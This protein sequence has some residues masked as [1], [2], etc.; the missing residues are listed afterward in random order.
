LHLACRSKGDEEL[1]LR[2][3][4]KNGTATAA[5]LGDRNPTA[6]PRPSLKERGKGEIYLLT[7]HSFTIY[8]LQF[9]ISM[10][11]SCL[12]Q[13]RKGIYDLRF[14]IYNLPF[15]LPFTIYH[16][17]VLLLPAPKEERHLRFTIYDLP[18]QRLAPQKEIGCAVVL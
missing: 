18:F 10:F 5:S 9:T 11:F 7:H 12:L 15:N 17:N 2:A 8:H 1:A 3:G 14:T 6:S 16:F 4:V 13:R